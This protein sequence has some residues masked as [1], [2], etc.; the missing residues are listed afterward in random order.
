MNPLRFTARGVRDLVYDCDANGKDLS[1]VPLATTVPAGAVAIVDISGFTKLCSLLMGINASAGAAQ[2]RELLNPPFERIISIIH[3]WGGSVVKF[4]GDAV[5]A[6]F[7]D[8]DPRY[9]STIRA[10]LCNLELLLEFQNKKVD[11]SNVA[12]PHTIGFGGDMELKIHIGIGVGAIDHIHVGEQLDRDYVASASFDDF[13]Q[14]RRE[15]FV[16]GKPVTEAGDMLKHANRGEMAVAVNALGSAADL[17]W[18]VRSERDST[19]EILVIS[20]DRS[21]LIR[22]L[23]PRLRNLLHDTDIQPECDLDR[24]LTRESALYQYTTAYLEESLSLVFN[25]LDHRASGTSGENHALNAINQI[26]SVSVIFIRFPTIPV[27]EIASPNNLDLIQ[28]I[29]MTILKTLR[30][31]GGCLR[32]FAC[33]DKALTALIVFGLSGFAHER[34]EERTALLAASQL[35][36]RL[37]ELIGKSF[38][39]GVTAGLVFAGIIGDNSRADGTVFGVCVNLA[40]RV[41]THPSCEGIMLCDE[42]LRKAFEDDDRD[43]AFEPLHDISLKGISGSITLHL[44]RRRE[45]ETSAAVAKDDGLELFGRENEMGLVKNLVSTW[46]ESKRSHLL[47]ITGISG[48]GNELLQGL[49]FYAYIQILKDLL[50]NFQSRLALWSALKDSWA[51]SAANKTARSGT[52]TGFNSVNGKNLN[53]MGPRLVT[54]REAYQL[55]RI[56]STNLFE[57]ASSLKDSPDTVEDLLGMLQEPAG[58]ITLNPPFNLYKLHKA[59]PSLR[60][61]T[62]VEITD[63]EKANFTPDEVG[64][65]N[66]MIVRIF[67]KL[68]T[69]I[70]FNIALCLDDFQWMELKPTL[71]PILKSMQ[72]HP[73][74]TTVPL[75]PLEKDDV[76]NIVSDELGLRNQPKTVLKRVADDI[77]KLT[78]GNAMA[79]RLICRL[80]KY[81]PS[82]ADERGGALRFVIPKDVT[83]VVVAQFDKSDEELRLLLK[84]AAV[85]G[86][87]FNLREVSEVLNRL[88]GREST[89]DSLK[90]VITASDKFHF[91]QSLDHVGSNDCSFTHNIIHQGILQTIVPQWV[92]DVH[93]LFADLYE[94][95]VEGGDPTKLSVLVHHL[96]A[97]PTSDKTIARKYKYLYKAFVVSTSMRRAMEGLEYY[98]LMQSLHYDAAKNLGDLVN[99]HSNLVILYHQISDLDQAYSHF[100]LCTR[101]LGFEFPTFES[102]KYRCIKYFTHWTYVFLRLVRMKPAERFANNVKILRK[103]F[104]RAFDA[105]PDAH[106]QLAPDPATRKIFS[107]LGYILDYVIKIVAQTEHSPIEAGL[108]ALMGAFIAF[109]T[110][111]DD[112]AAN[113]FVCYQMAMIYHFSGLISTS[114]TICRRVEFEYT[115]PIQGHNSFHVLGTVLSSNPCV[116]NQQSILCM[117]KNDFVD[118]EYHWELCNAAANLRSVEYDETVIVARRTALSFWLNSGKYQLAEETMVH[119][120]DW[121]REDELGRGVYLEMRIMRGALLAIRCEFA[122]ARAVYEEHAIGCIPHILALSYCLQQTAFARLTIELALLAT[123]SGAERA[124]WAERSVESLELLHSGTAMTSEIHM[125][126]NGYVFFQVLPL[127]VDAVVLHYA[128]AASGG[129]YGAA[130]WAKVC[131]AIKRFLQL[132]VAHSNKSKRNPVKAHIKIVAS[133]LKAYMARPENG[134]KLCRVLKKETAVNEGKVWMTGCYKKKMQ[135]RIYR[136]SR[137][138]ILDI[139][140][141]AGFFND[142]GAGIEVVMMG[143]P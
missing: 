4:A 38:A 41:M 122:E 2:V 142:I 106:K 35:L 137:S 107:E 108:A 53:V 95:M 67:S 33:D 97:T 7:S 29:F 60:R 98:G 6:C 15:Y 45:V 51:A 13:Q 99:E 115:M 32:Q 82:V 26:R 8:A 39:I 126:T 23:M 21:L 123:T 141:L 88:M 90:T 63:G 96:L 70:D 19:A 34:G 85:G 109:Y 89:A 44:P 92:A 14:R 86:L 118:C 84:I 120:L 74:A 50:A 135:A 117:F 25:R 24:A 110:D 64:P 31:Y 80:M 66:A 78:Q 40:A 91:I 138:D 93:L 116:V 113:A 11:F 111:A 124:R 20:E 3:R 130:H 134:G 79:S 54:G 56:S 49:P 83:A 47:L 129:C 114:E 133:K 119:W 139:T 55:S 61:N 17:L 112:P 30:A 100:H 75:A 37:R 131:D 136:I 46:I 27:A 81:E 16:S 101:G 103:I 102:Q 52:S 125:R 72:D 62:A 43:F 10:V 58:F 9:R 71:A 59:L 127:L 48:C 105:T 69:A 65:L 94:R 5:I 143:T 68:S 22:A 42:E 104:P 132:S 73:L 76:L 87:Y 128:A 12:L 77:Y 18:E 28:K 57:I 1:A 121:L 140:Q 36:D